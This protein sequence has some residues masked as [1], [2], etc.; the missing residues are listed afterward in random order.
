MKKI[1]R[2]TVRFLIDCS[3]VAIMFMSAQRAM[4]LPFS[5]AGIGYAVL[6]GIALGIFTQIRIDAAHK[7]GVEH[8]KEEQ[9]FKKRLY[10]LAAKGEDEFSI[11]MPN[12][13]GKKYINCFKTNHPFFSYDSK[14]FICYMISEI[15]T[16]DKDN[17]EVTFTKN[18]NKDEKTGAI[19][20]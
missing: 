1:F 12:L 16:I 9:K 10:E 6:F 2:K 13:I 5:W 18:K 11:I 19:K 8:G 15:H 14:E 7:Q 17:Y 4:N 20:V 3:L